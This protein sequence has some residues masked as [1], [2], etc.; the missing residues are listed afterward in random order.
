M[1]NH[2]KVIVIM[3]AYNAAATLKQTYD[4]V[5][6]QKIVDLVIVVDDASKDATTRIAKHCPTPWFTPTRKTKDMAP[7]R[8]PVTAWL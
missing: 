4:E 6:D 5:M 1:Y 3:P 7:T 2:Q 8:K